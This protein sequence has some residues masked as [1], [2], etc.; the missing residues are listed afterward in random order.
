MKGEPATASATGD[1]FGI[2]T[3]RQYPFAAIAGQEEM[4]LALL[5]AAVDWRLG[6]LLRGDKG[7]GKTTAARGLAELLPAGEGGPA[8]FCNLPVG[9]TEDRLLGGLDLGRAMA[10]EPALKAGLLAEAHGGVLYLDEVNLL[11]GHLGDALLDA[12]A[13]GVNVVEREGFSV[14]HAAEFCLLGSMNPEE[15]ALR[16]QLLDRFALS[17]DVLA[18]LEVDAR[19]EVVGR[20]M[21][22]ERGAEGFVAEWAAAQDGLRLQVSSARG[23]LSGVLCGEEMLRRVSEA[24]GAAGVRS[25][26]ADLAGVRAAV[27]CAALAG[28]PVVTVEHVDRVMGMVLGHR[29]RGGAKPPLPPPPSSSASPPPESG[30]GDG[31]G[32]KS[33]AERVFAPRAVEAGAVVRAGSAEAE[34]GAVVGSRG[35]TAGGEVDVRG[36]LVAR[37]RA[38]GSARLRGED[39]QE[40][41]R[42]RRAG[43]RFVAVVDSSGSHGV[44]ERMRVVKG[45]LGALLTRSFKA[46]DEVVVIVFRGTAAQVVVEPTG[47]LADALMGLEYLPTGGRTPLAAGLRLAGEFVVERSVVVVMTDGRA[48]VALAG[49]DAWEDALGVARGLGGA[50][51]VV[52]TEVGVNALGQA[53]KVAEAMGVRCVGLE[54]LAGLGELVVGMSREA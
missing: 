22:F 31:G 36:S 52:D 35:L 44:G 18:P 6:V 15:G 2:A 40:R 50:G 13:S 38:T 20:R 17:V 8:P 5:L 16:P 24:V 43:T 42:E 7:S 10:G 46:G 54:E 9:V 30:Q 45:A 51:L 49:G 1:P 47:V 53:A 41:V 14:R 21:G 4:K 29:V 3:R 28:A 26:R 11:P 12:A 37:V 23:R 25:L 33:V 34:R 19:L 27:A 32:G 48:N 39:L